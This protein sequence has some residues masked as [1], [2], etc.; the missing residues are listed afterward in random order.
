MNRK[1]SVLRKMGEKMASSSVAS[2]CFPLWVY[3]PKPP[4]A[5]L[6]KM[7]EKK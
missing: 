3:Q 1:A 6:A 4:A 5:I 7:Q 2:A